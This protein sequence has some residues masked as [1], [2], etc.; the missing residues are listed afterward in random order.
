M[1]FILLR[2][3]GTGSRYCVTESL[4]YWQCEVRGSSPLG[5]TDGG[6][7]RTAFWAVDVFLWD[8]RGVVSADRDANDWRGN[9]VVGARLRE[10]GL[11]HCFALLNGACSDDLGDLV[12]DLDQVDDR[13]RRSIRK[14]LVPAVGFEDLG[15]EGVS[16]DGRGVAVVDAVPVAGSSG[17]G[18]GRCRCGRTRWWPTTAVVVRPSTWACRPCPPDRSTKLTC[19]RSA[20]VVHDPTS[21]WR[22]HGGFPRRTSSIRGTR[23]GPGSAGSTVLAWVANAAEFTGHDRGRSRAAG[24]TVAPRSATAAPA[25]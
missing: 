20:V 10:E 14:Q 2:A 18:R 23:T 11:A 1:W 6:R 25:A 5:S 24:T 9:A 3:C 21:S 4:P 13:R 16:V 8:Q 22:T 17:C 12:P 19:H 7:A 15:V